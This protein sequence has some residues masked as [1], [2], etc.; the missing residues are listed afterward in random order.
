[1]DPLPDVRLRTLRQ[2]RGAKEPRLPPAK[3]IRRRQLAVLITA[4]TFRRQYD[5]RK[6][7]SREYI[8]SI[9]KSLSYEE[10]SIFYWDGSHGA[11]HS[12]LPVLLLVVG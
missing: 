1:M 4:Q 2:S 6:H 9:F 3:G 7:N 5:G 8:I 12:A 11:R 10:K